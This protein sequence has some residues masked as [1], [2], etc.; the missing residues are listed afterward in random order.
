RAGGRGG[1]RAGDRGHPGGRGAVGDGLGRATV[2]GAAGPRRGGTGGPRGVRGG[3]ARGRTGAGRAA[4]GGPERAGRRLSTPGR[5]RSPR[6]VLL[7]GRYV[8]P[9]R[10][11]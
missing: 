1:R 11:V 4:A 3:S 10:L 7:T 6:P 8:W 2:A 5:P 9:G